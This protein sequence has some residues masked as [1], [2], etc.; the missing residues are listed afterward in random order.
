MTSSVPIFNEPVQS[1]VRSEVL[2]LQ[3]KELISGRQDLEVLDKDINTIRRQVE[4]IQD[5][6]LRK[7]NTIFLLKTLLTYFSLVF[8]PLILTYKQFISRMT[9]TYIFIGLTIL[10]AII[11]YYNIRSLLSRDPMRFS[12]R[13]FTKTMKPSSKPS[14]CVSNVS[15]RLTPQQI[16]INQKNQE[17][18]LL[19]NRLKELEE[20][21]KEL[22][23]MRKEYDYQGRLLEEKYLEKYPDDVLDKQI[24]KSLASRISFSI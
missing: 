12:S 20:K 8:I 21:K 9:L 13:D 17:L 23:S 19:Q 4:I 2:K 24:E 6:S 11:I 1:E 18:E 7:E 14:K 15:R 10:F 3:S 22:D 16:E 5:S